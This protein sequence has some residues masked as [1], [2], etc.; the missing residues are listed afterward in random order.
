MA[1]VRGMFRLSPTAPARALIFWAPLFGALLVAP[2]AYADGGL[3][4]SGLVFAV[5]LLGPL[6]LSPM[7]TL[8][9]IGATLASG[10]IANVPGLDWLASP[11][12][13]I[14]ALLAGIGLTAGRS[15]MLTKPLAELFGLG[16]SL[17]AV[18]SGVMM[19]WA[20]FAEPQTNPALGALM[21]ILGPLALASGLVVRSASDVLTWVSPI[22]FLDAAF[23]GLKVA[24]ATGLFVLAIYYPWVALS[25]SFLLLLG[26][27][28]GLRWSLRAVRFG[29]S[30]GADLTAGRFRKKQAL[31]LEPE[32]SAEDLG[33]FDAFAFDIRGVPDRALGKVEFVTGR[34]YFSRAGAED[35]SE[36]IFLAEARDI[37]LSAGWQGLTL[38]SEQGS[39]L[40]PPRY[41]HLAPEL[42]Q[43]HAV[44]ASMADLPVDQVRAAA[45]AK[46]KAQPAAAQQQD[47]S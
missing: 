27:G 26:A 32:L 2:A 30:I 44:Q 11:L 29:F 24:L 35:P 13:F 47:A 33:P 45:K 34:W 23:Q 7:L 37:E 5:A 10:A 6:A 42:R 15:T 9:I 36:Q 39:V 1:R 31:P 14:P 16:E 17:L 21:L 46:P 38:K 12:Y 20:V 3:D 25:L 40:L 41:K 43:R 22:P 19:F 4:M 8:G 28:L 18:F